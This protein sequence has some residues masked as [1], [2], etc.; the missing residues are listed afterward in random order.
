LQ[1]ISADLEVSWSK[2][3]LHGS[4]ASGSVRTTMHPA[5]LFPGHRRRPA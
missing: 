1:A 5:S 2:L 4:S 3:S